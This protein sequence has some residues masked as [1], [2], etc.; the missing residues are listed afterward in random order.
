MAATESAAR[1][2]AGMLLA[3]CL[4]VACGGAASQAALSTPDAMCYGRVSVNGQP[5]PGGVVSARLGDTVLGS[6]VVGANAAAPA[7]YGLAISLAQATQSGEVLPAGTALDGSTVQLFINDRLAGEVAVRGGTVIRRDLSG[8]KALCSGGGRDGQTCVGDVDCPGG[9]CTVARALCD[10]GSADGQACQCI[11]AA[12]STAVACA[13]NP[14]RGTCS[15]GAQAG[16]CCDVAQNC[17]GGSC[18]G[19]QKLCLDGAR[20]GLPCLR[21]AQCPGSTCVSPTLVCL[22][23]SQAG[24]SCLDAAQCPG[25][26]CGQRVATPTVTATPVRTGTGGPTT[27]SP[28]PTVTPGTGGCAGD[29]D[30][31]GQVAI[32]EL[33]RMVNIALG[34]TPVAQCPA[35]DGNGDGTITISELI[36]AVSRALTSCGS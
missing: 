15:G 23:G 18:V 33:I 9:F 21:N 26:A 27:P 25:G 19:S 29:C 2:R 35:G 24:Y 36:A 3:V 17:A 10:G 22:D 28:T 4:S 34:T 31:D 5:V 32:S 16:E 13:I 11:E 1:R 7:F 20:K 6:S 12:C 14:G 8:G 30:G